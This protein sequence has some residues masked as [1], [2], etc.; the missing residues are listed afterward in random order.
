MR[1]AFLDFEELC[2][3]C[4][5]DDASPCRGSS[6]GTPLL[7]SASPNLCRVSSK[8]P[9]T[10]HA[11]LHSRLT[12]TSIGAQ[13]TDVSMGGLLGPLWLFGA[14]QRAYEACGWSL[15]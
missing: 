7:R 1:L 15:F 13:A 2:S 5:G 3:T 9:R 12:N 4:H 14:D 10:F 11:L 8:A 6:R